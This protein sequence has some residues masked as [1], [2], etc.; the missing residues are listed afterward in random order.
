MSV[1][2]IYDLKREGDLWVTNVLGKRYG[3]RRWTWGEKNEV[4]AK[5]THVDQITNAVSYDSAA[6]NLALFQLTVRKEVDGKFVPF[7]EEEIKTLEGP[8]GD[9]LFLLTQ[10]LN[11]VG[12]IETINL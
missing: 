12:Q 8:L 4:T 2:E 7:T 3:F 6:F 9:R 5:I 11:I 1:K 10:K